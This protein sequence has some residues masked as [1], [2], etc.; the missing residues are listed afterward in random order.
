MSRTAA[1]VQGQQMQKPHF[2]HPG[3]YTN[4]QGLIVKTIVLDNRAEATCY[5]DWSLRG[6][7]ETCHSGW[8]MKPVPQIGSKHNNTNASAGVG[9]VASV[10]IVATVTTFT[11]VTYDTL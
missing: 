6:V 7:T 11:A 1:S 9:T 10:I 4:C 2:D 5:S 8:A 3:L